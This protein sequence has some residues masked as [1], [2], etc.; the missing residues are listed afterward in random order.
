MCCLKTEKETKLHGVDKEKNEKWEK[1]R[2]SAKNS[3][4]LTQKSI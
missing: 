3:A 2:K 1:V 4:E